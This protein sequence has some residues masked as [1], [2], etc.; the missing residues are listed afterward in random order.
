MDLNLPV[1]EQVS[2]CENLLIA[3]M[4][5]GFDVFYG[6]PIYFEL[7]RRGKR[8]HLA[9][10]SFAD[11]QLFDG[12]IRLSD[13]LLGVT[14]DYEGVVIYFPELHLSRWFH[15]KRRE[16]MTIWCFQKTGAAPLLK[17][18]EMLVEHLGID[19]ILLIDGGVDSLVRGDESD[20]GTLIED[21]ISLFAVNELTRVRTRIVGCTAFGA[22]Q[23]LARLWCL[24]AASSSPS[25]IFDSSAV[26]VGGIEVR[27]IYFPNLWC[28]KRSSSNLCTELC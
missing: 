9:N 26:V 7:C 6:L 23:D 14:A 5:G 10:Y 25:S 3:G 11:L 24:C 19:G 2:A 28:A 1:L 27:R 20:T 13:T 8:V 22:E 4:G 15:Q 21:A 16:D 12:G 18:Y 17:N